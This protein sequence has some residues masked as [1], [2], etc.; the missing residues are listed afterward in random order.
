M[1]RRTFANMRQAMLYTLA[2]HIP[3]VGLALLPVLFGLPLILAPLHIAF[4]ELLLNP[5]CSLVFEAEE[6]EINLMEQSPRRLGEPLLPTKKIM[7]SLIYGGIITAAV[8]SLYAWLL[9]ASMPAAKASTATFIVLIT[10]NAMLILPSRSAQT[11][12]RSLWAGLPV[13]SIW[14]LSASLLALIIITKLPVVAEAFRFGKLSNIAWLMYFGM[15]VSLLF[16]LQILKMIIG[17]RALN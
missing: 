15:G 6:P 3:I 16:V 10:A 8:L 7:E 4:M 11:S 2:A 14:A 13:I 9:L 17:R 1:G 5:V 12:W